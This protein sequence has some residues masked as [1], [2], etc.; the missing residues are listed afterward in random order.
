MKRIV[1]GSASPRRRELM[2][3]IGLEFEVVVSDKEER[4]DSTVPQEI[5]KELALMKAENVAAEL[6]AEHGLRDTVIIGADT[7]VAVD[8]KILGKPKDEAEAF[9]MLTELQG[10]AHQVFTG[11]AILD[12]DEDGVCQTLNQMCIR[13]RYYSWFEGQMALSERVLPVILCRPFNR[14]GGIGASSAGTD[15]FTG[16]SRS[17][18]GLY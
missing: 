10:R 5:V 13:D 15:G 18:C 6:G 2:T 14:S 3:Q 8:D 9:E 4:Y 11:T 12:Y 7:I 17:V 16:D 1:L